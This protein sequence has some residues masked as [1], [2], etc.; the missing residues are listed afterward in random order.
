MIA[1]GSLRTPWRALTLLP[2]SVAT[3]ARAVGRG[4]VRELVVGA[5]GIGLG[6]WAWFVAFLVAVGFARGPLYGFVVPGPYDD[7]GA[8]RRSPARGRCTPRSGSAWPPSRSGC[9]GRWS[10]WPTG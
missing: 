4:R 3:T 1:P 5:F 10:R 7:A 9:G 6:V 2:R 8:G